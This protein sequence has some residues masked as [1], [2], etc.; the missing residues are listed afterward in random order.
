MLRLGE[1]GPG[2]FQST[3]GSA[4]AVGEEWL[5]QAPGNQ[6]IELP[7]YALSQKLTVEASGLAAPEP[8]SALMWVV[9]VCAGFLAAGRRPNRMARGRQ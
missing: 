3:T 9:V 6:D 1:D 7:F 4:T 2:L 8:S 5:D